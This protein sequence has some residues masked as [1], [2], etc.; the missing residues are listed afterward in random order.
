MSRKDG[1]RKLVIYDFCGTLADFQ[2]ANAYV[3][4]VLK[5]KNLSENVYEDFRVFLNKIGFIKRFNYML[6]KMAVNKSLLLYQ[7]K[8][9]D[10]AELDKLAYQYYMEQVK[11]HLI[12]KVVDTIKRYQ[13]DGD[14]IV[15]SSAGY[16]I[17]L[18]YFTED[19]HI[20][21]LLAT[22][23]K[24]KNDIFT[25]KI[26]DKDNYGKEKVKQL[27]KYFG[28]AEFSS[29]FSQVVGYSDS[30]SDMP[31]LEKCDKIICVNKGIQTQE[32]MENI[33]ADVICY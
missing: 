23:F 8:G 15:L 28:Q 25:G 1:N 5:G 29:G 18:K 22:D 11:P 27:E 3:R 12:D 10:Y 33:G 4:Y 6:P 17:Y 32:W 7:L 30:D 13:D 31:V 14:L 21:V 24:Y 2:T 16:K 19:Y 20:P 9:I 26:L